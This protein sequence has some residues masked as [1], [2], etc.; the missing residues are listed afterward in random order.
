VVVV[1]PTAVGK[2]AL[3]LAL[4]E[5]VGGEIVGADSRQV[6]RYM[7]IGTAKPTAGERARVPHHLIDVVN[8]DQ[9]FSLAQY[10]GMAY[11]AIE[12]IHRRGRVPL[13]VGGS[14]LY[15]WAVVRGLRVPAVPPNPEMRRE[16]EERARTEGPATLHQE[17]ERLDPVA[18][19]R[20][21]PRNLRRVIRALEVTKATSQPF[22]HLGQE[23]PPP[24][25]I[26]IIGLTLPRAELYRRIDQRVDRMVEAGLVEEVRGL[27]AR[28]YGLELPA[29][30]S[31]GYREIGMYLEGRLS[32]EEAVA[33]T[34]TATHRVARHQYAWF[35]PKD[36][37][38]RWFQAEEETWPAIQRQVAVFLAG[39]KAEEIVQ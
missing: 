21:D 32:L 34:K 35:S 7:D 8:P 12:D 9:D 3:A 20:I 1:G 28:G 33:R 13:L 30:A 39:A 24:Y 37:R 31:P 17:L 27:L 16:L 19:S 14:G 2:S 23:T 18:A 6:Y 26:L 29:M 25:D 38:I 11:A 4:A 5:T 22:S 36:P 15:V 10:Q